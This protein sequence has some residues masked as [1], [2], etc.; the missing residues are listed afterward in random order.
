MKVALIARS[1]LFTV[2]GGDTTQ[3]LKTGAG[4]QKLGVEVE[5]FKASESINYAEFDL[6]HFF[7]LIRPADHLYHILKSKKPYVISTIYLDYSAFDH[8]GR[9]L[10]SR[11][12]LKI[13]G[14]HG[15][16]YL[17]NIYRF[18]KKQDKLV[19]WEYL[20]GHKRAMKKVLA[21]AGLLLPNSRSE[22]QRMSHDLK[23]SAPYLV[24]PNGID[25]EIFNKIPK[26][27][28]REQ[29]VLC[30]AQIYGMKN[31]HSLIQVCN[32]LDLPLEIIGKAPPNHLK[33]AE[34]CRAI[35]GNKV[36]FFDHMPQ[37][38]L[39]KHYAG[40]KVHALPS[41]FETTGLSSLEAGVMGCNLVVGEGGDTKDYFDNLASFCKADDLASL[42]NAVIEALES[43][44]NP[45]I[46]STILE[47]YTWQ[48][49]AE[50]TFKA[51]Q[52]VL[53]NE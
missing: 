20:L 29:K 26:E 47:N 17:K 45:E 15:S 33:Y 34:Y 19:S 28:Q 53:K 31:Q 23:I 5:I 1:S 3:L 36:S 2:S 40:A 25:P 4:L 42:K 11:N 24:V 14:K 6:L 37:Q 38:E 32:E 39:I 48:K 52:K 50:V 18:A 22:Y 49:A 8:A 51:Y 41:W 35:A 43:P 27:I 7:N 12:L 10:L 46:R 44:I 9:G 30:V 21:G 16:E 13:L